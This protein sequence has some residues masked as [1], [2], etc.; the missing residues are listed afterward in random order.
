MSRDKK[1]KKKNLK[2]RKRLRLTFGT[3]FLAS[4]MV[5]ALIPTDNI[6]AAKVD[7]PQ[8]QRGMGKYTLQKAPGDPEIKTEDLD[9]SQFDANYPDLSRP[10]GK[11]HTSYNLRKR[12]DGSW[13]M[14][15][16]FKYA[17]RSIGGT[18]RGIITEYNPAYSE[19]TVTLSSTTNAAFFM[20]EGNTYKKFYSKAGTDI[21]GKPTANDG[22]GFYEYT[23]S[24]TDY[25]K[26]LQ[27][28]MKS[29][30]MEFLEKWRPQIYEAYTNS[31]KARKDYEKA[32]DEWTAAYTAWQQ[33]SAKNKNPGPEPTEV[34]EP[35]TTVF[36]PALTGSE[37]GSAF[38][39]A[40]RYKFYCEKAE[41]LNSNNPDKIPGKGYTLVP[42]TDEIA[43][44]PNTGAPVTIYI[45]Q[46]GTPLD[47]ASNDSNGFLVNQSSVT[48][49]GIGDEAFAGVI[50]VKNLILPSEISYIGNEAFKNSTLLES[51]EMQNVKYVG[52]RAFKGCTALAKVT[53]GGTS[54]IGAESFCNTAITSISI[55]Q[56]VKL[57]GTGAFAYNSQ[58]RDVVFDRG[59]GRGQECHVGKYAFYNCNMLNSVEMEQRDIQSLAEGVFAMGEGLM[60]SGSWSKAVLP[61]Y[62]TGSDSKKLG[63]YLFQGRSNLVTV[64]MP[65]N[66]GTGVAVTLPSGIFVGCT[67]LGELEFPNGV[68]G[69]NGALVTY[70]QTLFY[71]VLNPALCVK[72]PER[73]AG[74]PIAEPRRSTWSAFSRVSD[75]VPY[76]YRDSS[77]KMCYE[78]SDGTYILQ[79]NEK[80]ELTSCTL[81]KT[82]NTPID[83][84]IPGKVGSY[85][86]RT[87]SA[88]CFAEEALRERIRSITISDDSL[89]TLSDGVF[90]GLPRLE[91][92]VIGDS[93]EKI[94]EKAFYDCEKLTDV[95]FHSPKS[96]IEK[97][98]VGQDAFKTGSTELTL[99]GEIN[100]QYAPFAFAMG[101]ESGLIDEHGTRI[102]YKS[103]SPSFLTVMYDNGT[104]ETTL[105]DYPKYGNLDK[106]HADY[107]KTMEKQ[108]YETYKDNTNEQKNFYD[109]VLRGDYGTAGSVDWSKGSK[110]YESM[111]YG[112][113]IT[114]EFINTL[115]GQSSSGTPGA[116]G[117]P[118]PSMPPNPNVFSGLKPFYEVFSYSIKGN[119][120]N[121]APRGVF[122]SPT[123]SEQQWIDA[124]ENIVIP[125]G[126]T[127][128]DAKE[129]FTNVSANGRNINTYFPK[130]TE[131][132]R[133]NYDMIMGDSS[134]GSIVGGLFSG[135]YKDF[136]GSSEFETLEK[137]NDSVRSITLN[138]VKKLPDYA[139]DSCE[140]LERVVLGKACQDIG[141]APFRGCTALTAV[142]G[143]DYYEASQGIIYSK[144]ADDSYTIEECLA[145]RGKK[146][147]TSGIS[148]ENDPIIAKV[149]GITKGAFEDCDHVT[150]VDL[151]KAV[152]LTIVPENCFG[153]MDQLQQVMLPDSLR[154]I[155][156]KAF[157]DREGL[158]ILIPGKE[159]QITTDAMK[160][161]KGNTIITYKDT[162]AEEYGLYHQI[163]IEY[164]EGRFEVKFVDY[165]GAPLIPAQY[166]QAGKTA[167]KPEKDPV[168]EGFKFIG[169]KPADFTNVQGDMTVIAQYSSLTDT[170]NMFKVTFYNGDAAYSTQY[171]PAGG[172]AIP[173]L[174]PV[175]SG[176]VFI[177]WSPKTYL[178][179]QKDESINAVFERASESGSPSPSASSSNSSSPS[180][181]PSPSPASGTKYTVSVSGG[182]GSGSYT[183]GTVVTIGAYTTG[184]G[185]VFDKWTSASTGVGFV[186]ATSP[187]TT[188]TMPAGN[189]TITATY[190]T[191]LDGE[192]GTGNPPANQGT[193]NGGTGGNS[194]NG[195]GGSNGSSNEGNRSGGSTSVEITKP[196][197][198]DTDLASASVN[199]SLDNFVVKIMEDETATSAAVEALQKQYGDISGIRYF[200]M[201]ISLYD[202]TGK[203]KINDTIGITVDITIPLPSELVPY[204][205][206]NRVASTAGGTLENLNTRFTTID[207]IPCVRF[208]ASHFSPYVVYV[209]TANLSQGM[210][211]TT[212]K[213]GD[214]LHPKW[215]LVIGLVSISMLLFMKKEKRPMITPV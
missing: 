47:S 93:V 135:K 159:V 79:A 130:G 195:G 164:L 184:D 108:Y 17:V 209:D 29:E 210:M 101:K 153:G 102:C 180:P 193:A 49:F 9:Y 28:G 13:V 69:N 31:C 100:P 157:G 51:I 74:N 45:P 117:T 155:E 37:Q 30:G 214:F 204:A 27:S 14:N 48:I 105:L 213:T 146:V 144:N 133:K 207:G 92:V 52:N 43:T 120:Q 126:V 212:P 33:D 46:G 77:G 66:Y 142:D 8:D 198:P 129:F 137:G 136:E 88:N 150:Q 174:A 152:G 163:G 20:V 200:P 111:Y 85:N 191:T 54:M 208:T 173:P 76:I 161:T 62:I 71:D 189:V 6:E 7:M 113:W 122:E 64:V 61:I 16:Q 78:V 22:S 196:G 123:L 70:D 148:A 168:R 145:T 87:I 26:F 99:Y 112:P 154:R 205:G 211:D 162:A 181:S 170:E 151:G 12:S 109:A 95:T 139:F 134:V 35:A 103:L 165:N 15:W 57:V 56:S 67:G 58:L 5:V 32:L 141:T 96:G 158:R 73:S 177:G 55:P 86:I 140:Q 121:K 40:E 138:S 83:L 60:P 21:G 125:E 206:N 183:A 106:E 128:I 143:N 19:T 119:H 104:G 201:D 90:S 91:W 72:G 186:S 166:V 179:V 160:H 98:I 10:S 44:D 39:D 3:L 116:Q 4:A 124:T 131:E 82:G 18:S 2:L 190:K 118:N 41:G 114:Q 25:K 94:G 194:G 149:S 81:V 63:N 59:S 169:W 187:N 110:V 115:T 175:R 97:F 167:I 127:S 176:Y 89:R 197:I 107:R 50:N 24:Y 192:K 42:V 84:V 75:F 171:V 203:I 182:S 178:K 172:D 53:M 1:I 38:T 36:N 23:Y 188:F 156:S 147:G 11:P 80:E 185:K 202:S 215:F 65:P 34:S 199:G 132:E 68:G